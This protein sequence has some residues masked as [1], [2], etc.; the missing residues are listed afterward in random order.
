[1]CKI[2]NNR[3]KRNALT[4]DKILAPGKKMDKYIGKTAS[5]SMIP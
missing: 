2:L 1:M 3:R 4:I 5:K